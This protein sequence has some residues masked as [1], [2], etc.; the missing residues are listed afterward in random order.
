MLQTDYL[1]T[2]K[3]II[4]KTM[5]KIIEHYF[6]W[7]TDV[8]QIHALRPFRYQFLDIYQAVTTDM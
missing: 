2:T 4:N 6:V 5:F 3:P 8:L 7:W 1:K